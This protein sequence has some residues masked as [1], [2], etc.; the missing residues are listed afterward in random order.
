[1]TK[2]PESGKSVGRN[3]LL[4]KSDQS[5]VADVLAR[6]D[7]G[8]DGVKPSVAID[9]VQEMNPALMREQA[10]QHFNKTLLKKHPSVLKNKKKVAQA[11]TTKRSAITAEQQFRWHTLFDTALD[12][13]RAKN[14]GTCQLLGQTFGKLIHH[15]IVG[16][17]ETCMMACD[18]GAIHIIGS[19]DRKKHEKKTHDSRVSITMY[20]TGS[21]AGDSG[22]TSFLL[23]GV[24]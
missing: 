23:E 18:D 15:F 13:L 21:V 3:P 17:D 9:I 4:S 11:T 20:Q 14:T 22:P 7:R 6:K 10:M 19:A 2:R 1:V 24:K 16:G 5:F 8:N 12:E